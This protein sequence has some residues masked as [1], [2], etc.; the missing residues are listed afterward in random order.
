MGLFD[1]NTD[2]SDKF[3][4]TLKRT[5][6]VET[7]VVVYAYGNGNTGGLTAVPIDRT[8]LLDEE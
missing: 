6:D 4:G 1:R 8:R 2:A 7:D 3:S 5:V